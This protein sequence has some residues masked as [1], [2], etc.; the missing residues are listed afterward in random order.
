LEIEA[1]YT[2]SGPTQFARLL[3]ADT[4]GEYKLAP[5]EEQHL[6]DHYVDTSN[7]DIWRGG[8]ACRMREKDGEWL[9]TVKGRGGAEGA[10]HQ[11]EEYEME[12]QPDTQPHQWSDGPAR[13]LVFSLTHSQPLVGLCIIR[14]RRTLRMVCQSQR[15]IGE[16]SLDVVEMK[17]GGQNKITYEVEIELEQ[18]GTLEDLRVLDEILQDY[19]LRPESRSKFERALAL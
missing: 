8:Y 7:R 14:Q 12:I 6:I 11:R 3:R 1:K 13:E 18:D 16:L 10:I 9:L 15:H 2:T 4:L 5:M 19:G 17:L